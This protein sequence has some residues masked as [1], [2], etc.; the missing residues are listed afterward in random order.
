[1]ILANFHVYTLA[2]G[3][4]RTTRA[5]YLRGQTIAEGDVPADQ[6]ADDWIAKGLAEAAAAAE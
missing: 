6:S 2:P 3:A 4:D 1:M 5:E